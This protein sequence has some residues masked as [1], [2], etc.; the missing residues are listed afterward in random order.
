MSS[1]TTKIPGSNPKV[2]DLRLLERQPR[3]ASRRRSAARPTTARGVTPGIVHLGIGA[4]HRA[5]QAV[6]IDDLLAGGATD[7][8][9]V[10]AS[11]RSSD[12]RDALA[13]QDCLYTVA[14]RSGAGTDHRI[15][16]SVLRCE[17]ATENPAQSDRAPD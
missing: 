7:W 13:P 16:G 8:G 6:V 14:V 17:V 5:H 9:I 1:E 11:L 4:F 2:D 15:I 10:G 12:T 3:S